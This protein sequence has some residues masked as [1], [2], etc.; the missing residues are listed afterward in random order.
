MTSGPLSPRHLAGTPARDGA[1][2]RTLDN[3]LRSNPDVG[4]VSE[5]RTADD[6]REVTQLVAQGHR[7]LVPTGSFP[8]ACGAS[9]PSPGEGAA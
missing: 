6:C 7:I 3:F 9:A 8:Q 5:I 1:W 2:A 4:M